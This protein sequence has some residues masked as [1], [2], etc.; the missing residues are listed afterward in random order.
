[1]VTPDIRPRLQRPRA[2]RPI[3]GVVTLVALVMVASCR[4]HDGEPTRVDGDSR[5]DPVTTETVSAPTP[6]P[7]DA[8]GTDRS[9]T[10]ATN[11]PPTESEGE[12]A[13]VEPVAWTSCHQ[14]LSCGR[15]TAPVDYADLAG[16][17]IEIELVR[18]EATGDP[19][20]TVFVNPG[21]P[22]GSGVDY[23][24]GG[25]RLEPEVARHYH[26]VGFDPR[27]VGL[28]AGLACTVNRAEGPLPDASPDDQAEAE[29]LED[30]ARSL[31]ESCGRL[32][33][34]LL[35][36]LHTGAVARD[37]DVLR[38][39]VGDEQLHYVGFSYGTLIG[40][41]YADTFPDRVGHLVLDGVVDP[42]GGL[43]ALLQGQA[44]GFD[45]AFAQMEAACGVSLECPPGGLGAAH[46]QVV[47]TLDDDGPQGEVGPFEVEM[48]ALVAT[49][50]D[51][52]WPLYAAALSL[53]LDGNLGGLEQLSDTFVTVADFTAY[54]A[55]SC[56]DGGRPEGPEGWDGL[57]ADLEAR[58]PRFGAA[59]A[60]ELRV[61]A[62]WP[63]PALPAREPIQALGAGPIMVVGTTNDPATPLVNAEAVAATLDQ[64]HL[65]IQEGDQHVAYSAS[66]CVR[67]LVTD[68][69]VDDTPPPP[70]VRC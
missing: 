65:V 15:V 29:I 51:R 27:G 4:G 40:L 16:P 26:L 42:V 33:G 70:G 30:A 56:I 22:G 14:G 36:H 47:A 13:Q 6:A 39:A 64:G 66:A 45:A 2:S 37:L 50:S 67:A 7:G 48:A 10:S 58:S 21:G 60:N 18:V 59:I 55:V 57:V 28:S 49:Y 61:C 46:D 31:A 17:A 1:M 41:V 54:A 69:L 63:V 52:L 9:A 20:G 11:A 34:D 8:T 62:H 19:R 35:P 53:A 68:Y 23:V 5:G 38:R 25:F 32:D 43:V 44:V 12:P 3:I 24:V